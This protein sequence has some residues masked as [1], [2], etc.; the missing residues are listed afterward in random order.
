MNGPRRPSGMS[1]FLLK[2]FGLVGAAMGLPA[3]MWLLTPTAESRSKAAPVEVPTISPTI[4]SPPTPYSIGPGSETYAVA[5]PELRGLPPDSPPGTRLKL[6][7]SWG[8]P[9]TKRPRMQLLIPQ[10]VL[11]AIVPPTIEGTPPIA[12]LLVPVEEVPDLLYA[13]RYGM[14]SVTLPHS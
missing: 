14:L 11:Q 6:W 13:D 5:L 8:P 12:L 4:S 7:A 10:V 1:T 3:V 9:V 2:K